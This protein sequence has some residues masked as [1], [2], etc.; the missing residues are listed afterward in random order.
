VPAR[1]ARGIRVE[2]L[3]FSYPGEP[4]PVLTDVNLDLPAG[5]TV[6]LVGENGAGKS[7]LVKLLT[8]MYAPSSGK[9]TVD[10]ADLASIGPARWRASTTGAFQ[11]F[12]QFPDQRGRERTSA[13]PRQALHRRLGRDAQPGQGAVPA[14]GRPVR[15]P[16]AVRGLSMADQL[17]EIAKALS[18][19]AGL[20]ILDEPTASLSARGRAAVHDRPRPEGPSPSCS[21]AT[22]WTRLSCAIARPSATAS[23]SSPRRPRR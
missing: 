19:D 16:G 14:V 5:S 15:R 1:L 13:M 23:T 10:G 22:A 8:G 18:V 21:S 7:T 2:H 9:I 11:D 17:I 3:G 6:A 12:V 20:L 4:A